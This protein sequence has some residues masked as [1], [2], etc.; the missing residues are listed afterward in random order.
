MDG[1]TLARIVAV[2]FAAVAVTATVVGMIRK[3]QRAAGSAASP[4]TAS[5]PSALREG[6][7]R[8][9]SLG[10]AALLDGNCA[11]LWAEQRDRFLGFRPPS[12]SSAGPAAPQPPDATRQ[13]MR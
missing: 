4:P 7:R 5:P 10:E 13:G 3:E 11:R 1:K 6:L 2:T 9:Q 12:A 8:C